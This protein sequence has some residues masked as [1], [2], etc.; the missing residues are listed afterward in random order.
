M[1]LADR[2]LCSLDLW[3]LALVEFMGLPVPVPVQVK[4]EQGLRWLEARGWRISVAWNGDGIRI[5]EYDGRAKRTD[6]SRVRNKRWI[7]AVVRGP[8][9]HLWEIDDRPQAVQAGLQ[10]ERLLFQ[11]GRAATDNEI[12][13]LNTTWQGHYEG[14]ERKLLADEN[15]ET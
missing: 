2:E 5:A 6:I 15:K 10:T 4:T 13:L 8:K 14:W 7:A 3:K 12:A 9:W 11:G 1:E